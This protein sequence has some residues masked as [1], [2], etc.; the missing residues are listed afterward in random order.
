MKPPS[1]ARVLALALGKARFRRAA[2]ISGLLY[3]PLYLYAVGQLVVGR[4]AVSPGG[5]PAFV[6]AP[7]WAGKLFEPIA[8]YSFE[9]VAALYLFEGTRA[10][11]SAGELD[12]IG[13]VVRRARSPERCDRRGSLSTASGPAG[14]SRGSGC[15]ARCRP[16]SRAL[17]AAPRRS[18]WYS[19]PTSV[20]PLSGSRPSSCPPAYSGCWRASSGTSTARGGSFPET[21]SFVCPGYATA[22]WTASP[23]VGWIWTASRST[24]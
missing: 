5:S 12:A 18:P 1:H 3:L 19:A 21:F 13:A 24:L 23:N 7:D 11:S 8:G 15:S 6:V 9:P 10:V 4:G 16:C 17:R 20:S 14:G 2:A 22:L